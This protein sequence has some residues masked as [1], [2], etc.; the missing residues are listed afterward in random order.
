M[1][2]IERAA[3]LLIP[4]ASY[5]DKRNAERELK[6]IPYKNRAAAR[7]EAKRLGRR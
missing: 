1:T 5:I 3:C 7:E 4:G 6:K 2:P